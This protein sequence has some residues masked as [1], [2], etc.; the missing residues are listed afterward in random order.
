MRGGIVDIFP[1]GAEQPLRLDLF[2]DVLEGVRSFDPLSQRATGRVDEL[3]LEPV[4][5]VFLDDESITRFRGGYGSRFGAVAGQSDPLYQAIAA[6]R[7]HMGMEHWLPL[8]HEKLETLFDYLPEWVVTLDHQIEDALDKRLETIADYYEA[9]KSGE[10]GG[11]SS[12]AA[13]YRP[14]APEE[15]YLDRWEWRSHVARRPSIQFSPFRQ[16]EASHVLDLGGQRAR[17]FAPERT[18]QELILFDAVRDYI[19]S[20]TKQGKIAIIASYSPGTRERLSGLLADHGIR[21]S[22]HT[23]TWRQH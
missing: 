17:D 22:M 20:L 14:L 5:E 8:F 18:S 2:G 21:D 23:D 1:P 6:G 19:D 10:R 13:V 16:P 3:R 12:D 11:G 9:R 4:S 7:R 15:L